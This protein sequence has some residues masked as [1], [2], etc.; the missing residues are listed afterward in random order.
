MPETG[1]TIFEHSLAFAEAEAM[2][3]NALGFGF[4]GL[5]KASTSSNG[6]VTDS[7]SSQK[8]VLMT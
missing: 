6:T 2:I 8:T 3:S 1:M 4:F 5:P 7:E